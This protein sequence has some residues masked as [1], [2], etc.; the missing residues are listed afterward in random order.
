MEI[1]AGLSVSLLILSALVVSLKTF[2]LWRRT[3]QLPELLLTLMLV[4]A[5][6]LGYPLA[7]ATNQI[8]AHDAWLLH[9]IYPLVM[10]SGL[11]CLVLF[12]LKVFR[13]GAAW[14][15]ALAAL[16]IMGFVVCAVM[17]IAE[18]SRPNPRPVEE[19]LGLS[20]FNSGTFGVAYFWTTIEAMVCHRRL[21]RQLRL[22][23]ADGAVVNRV[24]LW[25]LMC[26]S[27][28]IAVVINAAAMLAGVFMTAP[29]VAISSIC[30]LS[31]ASCLFLAFHPPAWYRSWI[32]GRVETA[33]A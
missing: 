9:V 26:L 32:E 2:A 14:A 17:Y 22:G 21:K 3:G 16:T 18:A 12:T 25:G 23:L 6:V 1:F 24:L 10:N 20:L 29:I 7:I 27:A 13:P 31:L 8:P 11:A 28:G 33:T 4:G 19:M 30:G 15:E 5:T